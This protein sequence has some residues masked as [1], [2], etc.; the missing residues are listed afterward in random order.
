[1]GGYNKNG[2]FCRAIITGSNHTWIVDGLFIE[3]GIILVCFCP[4]TLS[5]INFSLTAG[6]KCGEYHAMAGKISYHRFLFN[7]YINTLLKTGSYP[8]CT[9]TLFMATLPTGYMVLG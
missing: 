7:F 3:M 4:N 8:G 1:M 9:F 2:H 6:Y 5:E